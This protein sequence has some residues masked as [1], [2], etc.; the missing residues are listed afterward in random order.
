MKKR[1]DFDELTAL[2]LNRIFDAVNIVIN[3]KDDLPI[4]SSLDMVQ[5]KADIIFGE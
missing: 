3:K 1:N 2:I 4:E 5:E